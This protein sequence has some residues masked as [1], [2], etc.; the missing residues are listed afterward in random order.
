MYACEQAGQYAVKVTVSNPLSHASQLLVVTAVN[1]LFGLTL[2]GSPVVDTV[3]SLR[4]FNIGM[5]D[6]GGYSCIKVDYGDGSATEVYGPN[7]F[8]SFHFFICNLFRVS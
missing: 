5:V 7:R 8:V 1:T 2:S 4:T 6:F 3:R